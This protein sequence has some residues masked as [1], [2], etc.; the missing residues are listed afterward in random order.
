MII[1]KLQCLYIYVFLYGGAIFV[2]FIRAF[3]RSRLLKDYVDKE[4]DVVERQSNIFLRLLFAIPSQT[5]KLRR[6][7]ETITTYSPSIEKRYE[8]FQALSRVAISLILLLVI[9]SLVAHK[10]CE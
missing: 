5:Q 4:E 1:S 2:L 7:K 9:F 8:R 3:F 10:A 6:L